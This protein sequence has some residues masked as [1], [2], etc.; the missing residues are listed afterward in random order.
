MKESKRMRFVDIIEKKRDGLK[1]SES[2]IQYFIDGV[3]DGTIPDYQ[4]SSFLMAIYFQ[5][6]DKEE[7]AHLTKAMMYSGDVVD[8]SMIDG[9]KVDKHSTGGVGDK[10]TIALTAM[11]AACGAKV[12]KMS[13]RGLGHTGGTLDKLESINGFECFISK[14]EFEK[15]VNEIGLAVIGQS[16]SM[17]YADKK[18]YALRDVTA[19]VKS[20]PLIASSIM[21]KKLASGSDAILLDVKYGEGAFMST[22]EEATLL[23][24]AMIDIGKQLNRDI[25]AV[26]SNMNQP[27]GNTIG[28]A[29]EVREAIDTLNGKGPNDFL[30]LCIDLGTIMLLQA[31]IC[32]T[33]QEAKERL[34]ES[35]HSK[36]ALN[37]LVEMVKYQGGDV[38]QIL[39]L[40]LLPKSKHEVVLYSKKTGYIHDLKALELGVLA[41]KLG[42]GRETKEQEVNHAVGI[43]LFKKVGDIIDQDSPLAKIYYDS[44]LS[45]EWINDFYDCFEIKIEICDKPKLIE[46]ILE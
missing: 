30:E 33:K 36:S 24:E 22:V 32:N 46:K 14:N 17:V 34:I 35:I 26:I 11:V 44:E 28:N 45:K 29:L 43:E 38:N 13:G 2:E 27:L 37:K 42:A 4:V 8:L 6:M 41:M 9:I 16:G 5:G 19:T 21:S 10:T 25:K 12:A 40:D 31:K 23:A 3:V 1:L 18:L 15:Q 39:N 7:T 20:I